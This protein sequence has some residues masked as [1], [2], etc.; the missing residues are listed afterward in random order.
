MRY[1][2]REAGLVPGRAWLDAVMPDRPVA[3]LDRMWGTMMVNSKALQLAGIDRH[4][5]TRAT[6]TWSATRLPASPPG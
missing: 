2:F 3:L 4:T 5:P 1:T 6:A